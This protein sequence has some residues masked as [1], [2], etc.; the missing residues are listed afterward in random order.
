MCVEDEFATGTKKIETNNPSHNNIDKRA[1]TVKD[2]TLAV[3]SLLT[4]MQ[5][6]D[7]LYRPYCNQGS[8]SGCGLQS[9]SSTYLSRI[10]GKRKKKRNMHTHEKKKR[11]Q[12]TYAL[13]RQQPTHKGDSLLGTKQKP[14]NSPDKIQN[15]TNLGAINRPVQNLNETSLAN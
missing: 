2:K 12:P 9:L 11:K 1:N 3:V 13:F 8:R 10:L 7:N 4:G 5:Q 6:A 15:N 14:N